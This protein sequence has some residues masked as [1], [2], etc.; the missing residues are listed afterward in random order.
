M[1]EKDLVSKIRK[2]EESVRQKQKKPAEAKAEPPKEKKPVKA[3]ISTTGKIIRLPIWPEE[4][5]GTP[6]ALLRSALFAAIQGKNR[7]IYE[8]PTVLAS[9]GGITIRYLGIQL[10]QSD[11]DVWEQCVHLAREYPLG[12]ECY[13]S[14]RS[15]LKAIKRSTGK[16]DYEWLKSVFMRLNGGSVEITHNYKAFFGSLVEGGA[17][18]NETG[19]YIIRLDPNLT[20]FFEA[21][22]TPIN[23]EQRQQLRRKPLAL[24]LQGFYASHDK[25]Y[26][27]KPKTLKDLSGSEN[28]DTKRF[29]QH[30]KNALNDLKTVGSIKD[31]EFND[32]LVHVYKGK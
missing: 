9:V 29:R 18:D 3:K 31:F 14:A 10:D 12:S 22:W 28:K 30:L 4:I 32:G 23:W 24:W 1:A 27:M 19:E 11:L 8:F 15:F 20:K 7:K 16:H 13:F 2:I 26:P 25:P 17:R 5:R 21:G 6:N